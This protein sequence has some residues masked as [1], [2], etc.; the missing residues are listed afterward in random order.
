MSDQYIFGMPVKV[1]E[2]VP[3][4]EIWLVQERWENG[5]KIV[6]RHRIVHGGEPMH[7]HERGNRDG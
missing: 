3:P 4:N 2:T 7:D 6:T 5:R 1:S